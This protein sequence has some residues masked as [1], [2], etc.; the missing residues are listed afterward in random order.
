MKWRMVR[1]IPEASTLLFPFGSLW[2]RSYQTHIDD[3]ESSCS[4]HCL[5]GKLASSTSRG[6]VWVYYIMLFFPQL[7]WSWIALNTSFSLGLLIAE[8]SKSVNN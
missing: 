3:R 7:A 4:L 5:V 8:E 2:N 1:S 6:A